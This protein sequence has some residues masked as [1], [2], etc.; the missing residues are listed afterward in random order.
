M[1]F[2]PDDLAADVE[3]VITQKHKT[4][5][6]F[7]RDV[8]G[9]LF[10]YIQT[11]MELRD[12]VRTPDLTGKHTHTLENHD[13]VALIKP[14]QTIHLPAKAP[15]GRHIIVILTDVTPGATSTVTGGGALIQGDTTDIM[16]EPGRPT[17]E[18]IADD[19]GNWWVI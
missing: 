4:A 18:V 11:N 19:A 7:W 1:A 6:P 16:L 2:N 12:I 14:G 10:K 3:R 13:T 15:R 5:R 9:T 8:F 17:L